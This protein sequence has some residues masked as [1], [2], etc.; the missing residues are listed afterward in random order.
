MDCWTALRFEVKIKKESTEAVPM[1]YVSFIFSL[2][3]S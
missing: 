3:L 2:N 1:I